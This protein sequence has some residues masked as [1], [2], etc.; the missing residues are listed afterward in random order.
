MKCSSCSWDVARSWVSSLINFSS[1]S[2]GIGLGEFVVCPD[3]GLFGI[4][5]R[6]CIWL[7]SQQLSS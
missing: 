7:K 4:W 1:M 2:S 5:L 3:L 6:L